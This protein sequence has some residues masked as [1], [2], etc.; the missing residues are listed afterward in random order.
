AL[1]NMRNAAEHGIANGA[2]GFLLTDW[3][4]GGHWQFLPVSYLPFI[5][6]AG[7]SW[8]FE[9]NRY[10]DAAAMADRYAFFD[11]AGVTGGAARDLGNAHL[12]SGMEVANRT[13]YYQVMA[14]YL[15]R[16]MNRYGLE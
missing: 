2:E 5:F 8:H 4:D 7:V 12:A 6:G 10:M 14:R 15:D 11:A 9:G 16:P 13:V 1:A 3:G